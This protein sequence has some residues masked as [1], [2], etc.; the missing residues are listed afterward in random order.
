MKLACTSRFIRIAIFSAL[1]FSDE[2]PRGQRSHAKTL[3]GLEIELTGIEK[4]DF[5]KL[6]N[7][8]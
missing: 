2:T 3:A 8:K 6:P 7:E 4:Q 1:V 5:F